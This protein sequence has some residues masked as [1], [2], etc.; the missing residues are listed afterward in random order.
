LL[1]LA[2]C[3]RYQSFVK[4][5]VRTVID[6]NL[7]P[8]IPPSQDRTILHRNRYTTRVY[9]IS[10]I[11]A[12]LI[13]LTYTSLRQDTIS[14][15]ID[16]ISISKYTQ[17][18]TKYPVTLKC[19]CTHIAIKYDKFI[20]QIE[21]QYHEVCSS[22]FISPEW[23]DSLKVSSDPIG[24]FQY[25]NDFR[26]SVRLQFLTISKFCALTKKTVDLSLSI[27]R[28]T[29]FITARVISRAE[30]DVQIET[31]IKQFKRTTADEFM[32]I[33]KLIQTINHGN[34]LATAFSSNWR[35]VRQY[36]FG[37]V[38]LVEEGFYYVLTQERIYGTDN[39]SCA[40]QS[41]CSTLTDFP[42]QTLNQ[43]SRQTILGFRVG[44]LPL[45][46]LLQ[47]S[48]SCLY[49]WSCL[50]MIQSF[51]HNN[52]PVPVELL[53]YSS[54][55]NPNTT[56]ETI[57]SQL[58]VSKW[59]H[60]SSFDRYFNECAPQSCQYSYST[61]FR[62]L[63][64]VTT[65]IALFG[66]LLGGLRFVVSFMALVVFKLYDYLK[67]KKKKN[68]VVAPVFQEPNILTTANENHELEAVSVPTITTAEVV[69]F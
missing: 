27:F 44:C 43:S 34:Q 50:D 20:S 33:L 49:N 58:F 61:K 2:F 18:Y 51:I 35:F 37:S 26:N 30:F 63:Y 60:R 3:A 64:V 45:E 41:N 31:L 62:R 9:L 1:F 12:L 13:L 17:L 28:Q 57:L 40:I 21:P 24:E 36:P 14:V 10:M 5:N 65:L 66:G 59:F 29:D 52:I 55:M 42:S 19:P 69:V 23:I 67:K 47:S 48:L 54:F 7:F 53:T 15:P 38:L 25:E 68:T 39:C 4:S 56:V 16:S 8:T 46:A 32:Q 22:N 6:L 11:V